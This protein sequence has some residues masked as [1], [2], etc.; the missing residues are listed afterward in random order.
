MPQRV[1]GY[2]RLTSSLVT[3]FSTTHLHSC[4]QCAKRDGAEGGASSP[5]RGVILHSCPLN[6]DE[7]AFFFGSVSRSPTRTEIQRNI[8]ILPA[9]LYVFVIL[10]HADYRYTVF[11][12]VEGY[13][14][15]SR[16]GRFL[17]ANKGERSCF[18]ADRALCNRTFTAFSFIP[19]IVAVSL[20]L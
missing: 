17:S 1:R 15:P 20:V 11:S 3:F 7:G 5:P 10:K 18:R 19:R 6:R 9:F 16:G 14:T 13:G 4:R 2:K 12:V 8:D